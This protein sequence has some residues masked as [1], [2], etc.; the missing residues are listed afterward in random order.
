MTCPISF[1]FTCHHRVLYCSVGS[2]RC[3][4]LLLQ[5]KRLPYPD[6][7]V[8]HFTR[9]G[10]LLRWILQLGH[11][12]L[13]SS[14]IF[15][16]LRD[17]VTYHHCCRLRKNLTAVCDRHRLERVSIAATNHLLNA[18]DHINSPSTTSPNTTCSP[19]K[20]GDALMRIMN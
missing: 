15:Q 16:P 12:Q 11:P 19:S 6:H 14:Q 3:H 18:T 7:A 9:N 4:E 2:K 10:L 17:G 8:P 1:T 20:S 13:Q 5:F